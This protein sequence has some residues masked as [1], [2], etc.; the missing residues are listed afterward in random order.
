MDS[1][2]E[3]QALEGRL[4]QCSRLTD[5]KDLDV[6]VDIKGTVELDGWSQTSAGIDS[7][8]QVTSADITYK[9]GPETELSMLVCDCSDSGDLSILRDYLQVCMKQ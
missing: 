5:R 1:E 7:A 2:L 4:D 3:L 8:S 6:H 9:H